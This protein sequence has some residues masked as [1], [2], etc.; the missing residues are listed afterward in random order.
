MREREGDDANG[1]VWASSGLQ[2][3]EE[4]NAGALPARFYLFGLLKKLSAF[5]QRG[6]GWEGGREGTRINR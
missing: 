6:M 5:S 4:T 2:V 3:S 1:A